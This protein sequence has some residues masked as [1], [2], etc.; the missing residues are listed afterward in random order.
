MKRQILNIILLIFLPV[1]GLNAQGISFDN[2]G[3]KIINNGTFRVRAGQ[4]KSLPDTIG[5][6][7]EFIAICNAFTQLIPNIT[8]NQLQISGIS[9]KV[10]DSLPGTNTRPLTTQDSLLIRDNARV[11]MF[12]ESVFAKGTVENTVDVEGNKEVRMVGNNT[13][14][15]FGN[16]KYPILN[17]DNPQ[18][19]NVIKNGGFTVKNKLELTRGVLNNN[20]GNNFSMADSSVIVRHS[21][22]SLAEEPLFDKNVDL[23]YVGTSEI[24]S[25]K[26][27]PT[28]TTIVKDLWVEN[29]GGLTLT[30]NVTVKNKIVVSTK[31]NTEPDSLNKYILTLTSNIDPVYTSAE[32]EIEG[33]LRRTYLKFDSTVILFNNRYTYAL[34]ANE[35]TANGAKELTFRVKPRTFPPFLNGNAKVKRYITISAKDSNYNPVQFGLSLVVGYGWRNSTDA[36]KDENNGLTINLLKLQRWTGADWYDQQNDA[37]PQVDV[38]NEWGFNSSVNISAL[39]DFAI[40]MPG[41]TLKLVLMSKVILEGPFRYGSMSFDLKQKNLLPS[42]PPDIYPYNLDP[43]RPTYVVPNFPDSIVDWI[44]LEFRNKVTGSKSKYI[45]CFVKSDGRVCGR[46]GSYPINLFYEGVDSGDYYVAVRHRN[47]LSVITENPVHIYPDAIS[48]KEIDFSRPELLLGRE[49]ALRIMGLNSDGSLLFG[50]IAGDINGDGI[51]DDKDLVSTWEDRDYEN[52]YRTTDVS[53]SGFFNTRDFNFVWNN[54]GRKT[55]VP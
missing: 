27:V 9:L 11:Q 7:V 45:T 19:V 48:Q 46:D 47:H 24:F 16:G 40:G 8:Y 33:S 37:P 41:N 10:I 38:V 39:G 54:K 4:V 30:K 35:S 25:G 18:N 55:F 34:F 42:T 15:M 2:T 28:D 52:E 5:G 51:I 23:E 49:N 1:I 14:N 3:G 21:E 44:V 6:R 31:I 13:Q 22:G 32:A 17:I 36:Q 50:M 20:T 29:V 26:E 53:M 12:K 43:R